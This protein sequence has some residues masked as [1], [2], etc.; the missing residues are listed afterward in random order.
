[1]K[2]KQQGFGVFEV[3]FL[4][5]MIIL[6]I[7][8]SYDYADASASDVAELTQLAQTSNEATS[9]LQSFL[10]NHPTPT[11]SELR[12]VRKDVN[13]AVVLEQSRKITGNAKLL[14]S[15]EIAKQATLTAARNEERLKDALNAKSIPSMSPDEF[16]WWLTHKL[17]ELWPAVLFILA[18][19]LVMIH[20]YQLAFS[21]PR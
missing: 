12:A 4:V 7:V 15:A 8:F 21:P 3:V 5:S 13:E 20:G 19:P 10:T 6:V 9:R 17:L 11:N 16:M 1:M 14:S 18:F 2:T